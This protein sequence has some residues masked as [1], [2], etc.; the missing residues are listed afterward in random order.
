MKAFFTILYP[1]TYLFVCTH[2][3]GSY[4]ILIETLNISFYFKS[5]N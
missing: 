5:D 2:D 4:N 1:P 3:I